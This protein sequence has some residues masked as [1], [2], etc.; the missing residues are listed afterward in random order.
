MSNHNK[1]IQLLRKVSLNPHNN[2]H[3]IVIMSNLKQLFSNKMF[4]ALIKPNFCKNARN[5]NP[6]SSNLA[7]Q[8]L[9]RKPHKLNSQILRAL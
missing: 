3:R 1:P 7:Y 8:A 9:L 6:S 5:L 2:L 4:A